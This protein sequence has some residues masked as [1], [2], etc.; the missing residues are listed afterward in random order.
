MLYKIKDAVDSEMQRIVEDVRELIRIPSRNPPGEERRCAE[1]IHSRLKELGLNSILLHEPYADR[2]QV[3]AYARDSRFDELRI[4]LNGHIDT[5][6]E[7]SMEG[8]SVDPFSGMIKDGKIYG[9][10][11][12]DM[13]SAL[14]IMMHICKIVGRRD[15]LLC[16]AIG[17]E[18]AEPGT[19]TIL[20]HVRRLGID[21]LRYGIVMEPTSLKIA[22]CQ[23]GALWLN[24]RVRGRSAHASIPTNG[25]NAIVR[26]CK[27]IG[28]LEAYARDI[29]K[30]SISNSS[31]MISN[32]SRACIPR[33]SVT[34]IAG[35]VKENIVPDECSF[36]IDRRVAPYESANDV[37]SEIKALLDAYAEEYEMSMIAERSPV[38]I[39]ESSIL[40]KGLS[41]AL[42][43][44][45]ITDHPVCWCFPGSTDNEHVVREGIESIVWGPGS[46]EQAHA[47]DEHISIEELRL[48]TYALALLLSKLGYQE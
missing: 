39:D 14:A 31:S 5:V 33:C 12:A 24:V 45:G 9:R 11:A 42:A 40:V 47:A 29:A 43:T 27:A 34:M 46:I 48:S 37:I 22:T 25:I 17:E 30:R 26:A 18:R 21:R 4:V 6:P 13:K 32:G 8:W 16:F 36:T 41:D 20:K 44:I 10:G 23:M 15:L 35:G 1:Y 2:P 38:C 3:I 19:S 7:G 28:A